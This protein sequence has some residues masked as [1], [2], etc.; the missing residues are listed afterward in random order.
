MPEWT[1]VYKAIAD[2]SS[3]AKESAKAL[4]ELEAM[5]KA[6][7]GLATAEIQSVPK[8]VAA[9]E[10]DIR[11][12]AAEKTAMEAVTT[13][14][15]LYNKWVQWQGASSG[16][17]FMA[18]L[19]REE[20][21]TALLWRA[22]QRGFATPMM[23]YSWRQREI[24]QWIDLGKA[25]MLG[26]Q[27]PA[28]YLQFLTQERSV[29]DAQSA[30]MRTQTAAV[31]ALADA[32]L[33]R[34][35]ALGSTH[36]SALQLGVSTTS[37]QLALSALGAET[38][39][40]QA[41]LS[42]SQLR[43]AVALDED[44]LDTLGAMVAKPK[45]QI[46]D[47]AETTLMAIQ[48]ALYKLSS[49][50]LR[51]PVSAQVT[52]VLPIA[53]SPLRGGVTATAPPLGAPADVTGAA[54]YDALANSEKNAG[55]AALAAK[56][57]VSDLATAARDSGNAALF[58]GGWWGAWTKQL[59]LFGGAFGSL[60]IVGVTTGWVVAIHLAIE[61]LLVLIPAL[62]ALGAG[63]AAIGIWGAI[64]AD[65][66]QKVYERFQA[67]NAVSSSFGQNLPPITNQ[68]HNLEAAA[69]PQVY[70]LLGLALGEV[71]RQ[72][73]ILSNIVNKVGGDIVTFSI[74]TVDWFNRNQQ[75]IHHFFTVGA[76]DL[77]AF[78]NILLNIGRAFMP[79]VQA[80]A[81]TKVAETAL[82]GLAI[83]V[84]YLAEVL[85]AIPAPLLVAGILIHA[86][87]TYGG[88]AVTALKSMVLA[89]TGVI[90]NIPGLSKFGAGMAE[91]LGATNA[92]LIAMKA[93]TPAMAQIGAAIR[94]G[95][96]A[97]FSMAKN[98]GLTAEQLTAVVAKDPQIQQVAKSFGLTATQVA[99]TQVSLVSAGKTADEW[100]QTSSNASNEVK[101]G[102]SDVKLAAGDAAANMAS[103][104]VI[105]SN[106]AGK[107]DA[108][109][110]AYAGDLAA[111]D[112]A[113]KTVAGDVGLLGKAASG[114]GTAFSAMAGWLAANW[115]LIA[116]AAAAAAAYLTYSF[117]Q[118]TQSTKDFLASAQ[119]TLTNDTLTQGLNVVG[120]QLKGI[121]DQAA[122]MGGQIQKAGGFWSQ[123]VAN[124]K[125][126][127]STFDFI[128]KSLD[129]SQESNS[130][131]ALADAYTKDLTQ[132]NTAAQTSG[133]I[134]TKYGLSSQESL[135]LMD[136]A[137]VHL[138]D[139]LTLMKQK[140]DDLVAG[141][142]QMGIQ[143][144]ILYNSVNAVTFA[145][146]QQQSAISQI[147]GG[148]DAF[149]KTVSAAPTNFLS[150][151]AS[152]NT[153]TTD[154]QA[155][156]ATFTGLGA[157]S[158]TLQQ[159]FLAAVS[160]G[161]QLIDSLMNQVA[162]GMQGVKGTDLL[163]QSTKDLTAELL[164]AAANSST[165]TTVLYALAQQGG[166]KG[167]DSFK[168]LQ[169]WVN[170]GA[171]AMQKAGGPA[172]DLQGNIDTAA[173]SVGTL[174]T[175][176]NNMDDA[177]NTGL[178]NTMANVKLMLSGVS[179]ELASVGKDIKAFNISSAGG[180]T[181]FPPSMLVDAKTLAAD[182]TSIT[183]SAKDGQG[184][185]LTWATGLGLSL[186][187]AKQL[188]NDVT[189]AGKATDQAGASAKDL[190]VKWDAS[191]K[192]ASEAADA[193]GNVK[194]NTDK[195]NVS[196]GT[197]KGTWHDVLSNLSHAGDNIASGFKT[198]FD[199]SKHWV[200]GFV[201]FVKSQFS[202]GGTAGFGKGLTGG[203]EGA[204]RDAI[205]VVKDIWKGAFT[206]LLNVF[207]LFLNL[208]SGHW[209]AAWQNIKNIGLA[210]W[211][212]MVKPLWNIFYQGAGKYIVSFFT[213]TMAQIFQ[214][215]IPNWAH[216]AWTAVANFFT[217]TIGGPLTTFWTKTFESW[218]T[219]NIPN[220]AK[221]A[222]N[223][224]INF[225]TN[226]VG[227]PLVNFFT[228]TL[229]T[230]FTQNIPNWAHSAW[231]AVI[232]FF[233]GTLGNP[234]TTFWTRTFAGWFTNTIPTLA[235]N[236]WTFIW[237][238]FQSDVINN[239]S[240]FF[241][242]TVPGWL[243]NLG[244][245]IA[246]SFKNSF[247]YA[248]NWVIKYVINGA[249]GVINAV[250][251]VVGVPKIPG[252]SQ[253]GGVPQ[254]AA[255]GSIGGSGDRDDQAILAMGG[256][257]MLRKPARMALDQKYGPNFLNTLN[258]ADQWLG[259]GSRG[260]LASQGWGRP[261]HKYAAGGFV[262]PIGLNLTPE[263][264][265]MGV[266]YGGAGPLFALG[267][268]TITNLYN[269]GW[270][271]GTYIGLHL[272]QTPPGGAPYWYYAEDIAPYKIG[273]GSRVT[274]GQD[275]AE[276]T[277]GGSGIE[278]GFAAPPGI[279]NTM[280][281]A[282][283]ETGGGATGWGVA[284]SNL[285]R[286][287][288]GRGGVL[289]G[290]VQGGTPGISGGGIATVIW[291]TVEG[292]LNAAGSGLSSA[293][294]ALGKYVKGGAS[295]LL[296]LAKTGA[297]A[298][299]DAVWSDTIQ[300]MIN[301]AGSRTGPTAVLAYSADGIKKGIDSI[302]GAKDS[303]A[304]SLAA[305]SNAAA[306]AA[307]AAGPGGGN[308]A[309]NQA[310]ARQLMPAWSTGTEWNDWLALWNQ[311][312]GWNQFA[313]NPS[314]G[315][316]GIPQALP[317]TK[318]P[319]A[320]WPAPTGTSNPRAQESWGISYIQGRYGDPIGAWAHEQAYNWYAGGGPV[321][322]AAAAPMG[323]TAAVPFAAGG[324]TGW[325]YPAPSGLKASNVSHEGYRLSWNPVRGPQ[326]QV[327]PN[328]TV[329]TWQMNNQKADQFVSGST[330]TSEYG[331]GGK[332]MHPGWEYRTLVW[333]NTGPL[334][335]PHAQTLVTLGGSASGPGNTA[336]QLQA[337]SGKQETKGTSTT[338]VPPGPVT[339]PNPML[340]FPKAPGAGHVAGTG[341]GT[342]AADILAMIHGGPRAGTYDISKGLAMGGLVPDT[343]W[344][345][346][347]VTPVATTLARLGMVPGSRQSAAA[348]G[349]AAPSGANVNI[350]FGDINY[351]RPEPASSSITHSV[352]KSA[353][354]AGR[355][356]G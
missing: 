263:R 95:D 234:L 123:A 266:D 155:A 40:P 188:W 66:A 329:Q 253:V 267:S 46:E 160:G 305:A 248:I 179:G 240:T 50:K 309:Q 196:A 339:P 318:M 300:P 356:L 169:K 301:A 89:M 238:H 343:S 317:F 210:Y 265:D 138:T 296:S 221:T 79:L 48:A 118:L 102:L 261:E 313:Q 258:Q 156:G 162:V 9:R 310:L 57:P 312:S 292:L 134:M 14:A 307:V 78:G 83:V 252:V 39:A 340:R 49:E 271:G 239:L 333:A 152:M 345:V 19:Q 288:G 103:L 195:A 353:F 98:L 37:A 145:T 72:G 275:I 204:F 225:F 63:L 164:P 346:D 217:I 112:S 70:Q 65:S 168:E 87:A 189:G 251:G 175:D 166:Y 203:I 60:A 68:L 67:L 206:I 109:I 163:A 174:A 293:A 197:L 231:S 281:Q 135:N 41:V 350:T 349:T 81:V 227:N 82:N 215:D 150:F 257:Y 42:D 26:F 205:V 84:G 30:S 297:R 22:R 172:Q 131:K 24:Q 200:T 198:A 6:V 286:S 242:R 290:A 327:P 279:G 316:Y 192:M 33:R 31:A 183:G 126:G 86:V 220:W 106:S 161:Q 209:S 299:F 334:A 56:G 223:A 277:G 114:V 213:G 315:A 326:G 143:G 173:K 291:Q 260:T 228:K 325:K 13:Q 319:Q 303:S 128:K 184:Y 250:T 211:N 191:R 28:Q 212:D 34:A 332:G 338:P 222:W 273:V 207:D 341:P 32:E 180:T 276:A 298:I 53:A 75:A 90:Q 259:S 347:D 285:I 352:Q 280:A 181:L 159:G 52:G 73:N 331:F 311:E 247:G 43:G 93:N 122:A 295:E 237:T 171:A 11:S 232:N 218:L 284:A 194:G 282:T 241:T 235:H 10:Q 148:W 165:L 270:P 274:A 176:I 294:S 110:K 157:N 344:A 185:F 45:I 16:Q 71:G 187:Q 302:L 99:Q 144:G 25:Q 5:K 321:P 336:A 269:S 141:W 121:S 59:T 158:I 94:E 101:A 147:T 308:A 219:Q 236:A 96:Q 201:D 154:A 268:G 306:A 1:V 74:K 107:A 146:L 4:A 355:M 233:T 85:K 304:Q 92:Q 97:A 91:S 88:L 314:S 17:E 100:A 208:I 323:A 55:L 23:D 342:A 116:A 3:I 139:S 133:Y 125:S 287:L 21:Y 64:A 202:G 12:L 149:F 108:G 15:N 226:T 69:R 77:A 58:A 47:D 136:L 255:G 29:F 193:A 167:A 38:V 151:Q 182:L 113:T 283:G 8:V 190:S 117:K 120:T 249:I 61:A 153:L 170:T 348:S 18:N 320:A 76:A 244:G 245:Q 178:V 44:L 127:G 289:S 328:Y 54:G 256:E 51:V 243:S 199:N 264:I 354:L 230:W 35:N 137:G 186:P 142:N 119:K 337:G 129:L 80:G 124:F 262:N 322:G 177:V 7:E 111:A 132:I 335:P 115:I 214:K 229:A 104:G 2:F 105:A 246:A 20:S 216:S 324:S 272:D 130:I 62:A 27:Y 140:V 254:A 330:N 351:P 36:L 278:V 224:V